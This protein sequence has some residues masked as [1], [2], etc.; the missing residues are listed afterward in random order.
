MTQRKSINSSPFSSTRQA[1]NEA[2]DKRLM[3]RNNLGGREE[4]KTSLIPIQ[5]S[6]CYSEDINYIETQP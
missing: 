1:L 3:L 2:R 4:I 6:A 5:Q